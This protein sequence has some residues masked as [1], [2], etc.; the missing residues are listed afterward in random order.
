MAVE[1]ALWCL[2]DYILEL[3]IRI[4]ATVQWALVFIFVCMFVFFYQTALILSF[5]FTLIWVGITHSLSWPFETHCQSLIDRS[6]I[7]LNR[8]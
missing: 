6:L 7:F 5:P 2:S 4:L 1:K 3:E 8:R